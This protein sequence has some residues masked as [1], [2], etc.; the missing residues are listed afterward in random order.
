MQKARVLESKFQ[1]SKF[2]AKKRVFKGKMFLQRSL[3]GVSRRL[4]AR[5][6]ARPT[7]M[8]LL[9]ASQGINSTALA[10]RW[11]S[12]K[13]PTDDKTKQPES[14]LTEDLLARAGM[15]VPESKEGEKLREGTSESPESSSPGASDEQKQRWKGTAKKSSDKSSTDIK[16]EKRSNFF[17]VGLLGMAVGG[18]V[19]LGRDWERGEQAKHPS[20]PGGYNPIHSFQRLSARIGDIFNYF[21]EP[22]FEELLPDPLPEPY[23][24]P[25]TLVLGLDDLLVHSEWSR[26]HGWRTAKR[27][28]LDYFLGYLAQYYEIIIFSSKYMVYS[29]KVVAKLD[30]YRSS[31]SHALFREA[32]RYR[33]G[34]VI[35]DISKLNRDVSKVII[36]DCEPDAYSM[37][38]ENAVPMKPWL[39]DPNDKD[40]VR[41]IPFLEWIATQP[42]KDVR[43]ILN[44]FE[45]SNIP[46]EYAKREAI[47]RKSFEEDWKKRH[48]NTNNGN[49]AAKFLGVQPPTPPVP[50]M[51]QDYIRQEGQ[52]GYEAFQKYL[53]ENGEKMLAEEK[54]REREILNEQKFTLN[55]LVTEGMPNPEEIIEKQ[56]QRDKERQKQQEQ[57]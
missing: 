35:K 7:A 16:R 28:G 50:M 39:G 45:G 24:R 1:T 32:T 15:D 2:I 47:A 10:L 52:K 9:A 34:K 40:L 49:W 42:I 25:L 36:V 22:I 41:L 6:L 17:Y 46:D 18:A 13:P 14:I 5:R 12:A 56:Q 3:G 57:T 53:A 37:Q 8:D 38:P 29:E 21:N 33:D 54:E 43:P 31:I 27:P 11:S 30:P 23:S 26:E 20:I 4:I 19:Y 55:K 44:T 51:P 48:E